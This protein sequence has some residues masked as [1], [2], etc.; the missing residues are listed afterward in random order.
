MVKYLIDVTD[1]ATRAKQIE[2][3]NTTK[4]LKNI[5]ENVTDETL[6]K[7]EKIS[8][9]IYNKEQKLLEEIKAAK[10]EL[11]IKYEGEL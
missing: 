5:L 7:V 2:L 6:I 8:K 4:E 3:R 9:E 1:K 10:A 11:K